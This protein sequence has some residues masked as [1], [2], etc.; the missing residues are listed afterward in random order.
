MA[1]LRLP[2]MLTARLQ[3]LADVPAR[4]APAIAVR[5]RGLI[6]AP[7]LGSVAVTASGSAV[8]VT[9]VRPHGPPIHSVLPDGAA[10]PAWGAAVA[11]ETARAVE[12]AL[13]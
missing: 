2:A 5:L 1:G 13:R 8:T 3:R 10:P 7:P 4:A 12:G 9:Q 11:E 6:P